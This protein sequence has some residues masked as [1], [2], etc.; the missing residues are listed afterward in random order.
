MKFSCLQENLSKALS[1]VSKAVSVKAPLPIL[2]NI[3]IKATKG[4]L[5]LSATDLKMGIKIKLGAKVEEEGELTVPARVFSD[6]IGTLPKT[7]VEFSEESQILTIKAP[8]TNSKINGISAK[9]FP[10]FSK[11]PETHSLEIDSKTFSEAVAKTS[12]AAATDDGRPI[13][14]GLYFKVEDNEGVVVGVDGFRLAE[15]KLEFKN[16]L[17]PWQ[18][19]LPSKAV[20]EVA[21]LFSSLEEPLKIYNLPDSG[22]VVFEGE[23]KQVFAKVLEGEFPDYKKIIPDNFKISAD[24]AIADILPALKTVSVFANIESSGVVTLKVQSEEGNLEFSALAG[25]VGENKTTLD[26]KV[27]GEGLDIAFNAKYLMD[28]LNAIK[29]EQLT[30]QFND[31]LSPALVTCQQLPNYQ[32]LIMPVRVQK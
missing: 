17:P 16:K 9:E 11:L 18:A 23:G 5:E 10:A 1:T 3:L 13:L 29:G 26:A 14:T 15:F 8:Q 25:S 30:M 21:R 27:E 31:S 2:E 19:V 24:A 4:E 28:F 20:V 32:Y 12:F 7:T 22:E 6:F